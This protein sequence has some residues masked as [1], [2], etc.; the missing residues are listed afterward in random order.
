[1]KIVGVK[2]SIKDSSDPSLPL[3]QA[4]H[5]TSYL[6]TELFLGDGHPYHER[7]VRK[8]NREDIDCR[9][10]RFDIGGYYREIVDSK[11]GEKMV[12]LVISDLWLWVCVKEHRE[13]ESGYDQM[14]SRYM[15]GKLEEFL[16]E[17]G[18]KMPSHGPEETEL[19][20]NYLSERIPCIWDYFGVFDLPEEGQT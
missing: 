13:E 15:Q 7:M 2:K 6:L 1:M 14:Q 3:E 18:V 19:L 8:V 12:I 17:Q 4:I 9:R 5:H 20:L 11:T 16:Y 10:I